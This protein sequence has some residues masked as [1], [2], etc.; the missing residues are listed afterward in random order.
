[1]LR[2]RWLASWILIILVLVLRKITQV[3]AGLP[4]VLLT[5]PPGL[6]SSIETVLVIP[7]HGIQLETYR[8]FPKWPIFI[9]RRFIPLT[10]L[11]DVIINEGLWGWNV[12]H[13][14]AAV[15]EHSAAAY[16]LDVV[17]GVGL[18]GGLFWCLLN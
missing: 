7:P 17:F 10:A 15:K 9:S 2:S 16:S 1:M 13:Y 3:A 8:G 12:R 5:R 11:Q 4:S 6:T 18:L 14:L